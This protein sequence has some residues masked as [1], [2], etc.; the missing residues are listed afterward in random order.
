MTPHTSHTVTDTDSRA[1]PPQG[2]SPHEDL[3]ISEHLETMRVRDENRPGEQCFLNEQGE[4]RWVAD[5]EVTRFL[6][7]VGAEHPAEYLTSQGTTWQ[8][9]FFSGF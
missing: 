5:S 3:T 4:K 9:R 2:P 8:Q 6:R 7:R 1:I